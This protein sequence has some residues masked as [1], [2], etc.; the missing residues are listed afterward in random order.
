MIGR[1]RAE[2][3]PGGKSEIMYTEEVERRWLATACC[4]FTLLSLSCQDLT[5]TQDIGIV[6]EQAP[7]VLASGPHSDPQ[8]AVR[9]S[10]AIVLAVVTSEERGVADL[11]LYLSHSGGDVFEKRLRIN[12]EPG[13]VMSHSEGSPVFRMGP[14]SRFHAFW[15]TDIGRGVRALRTS[16]SKD[17]LNSFEAPITV[18]TGERGTPAFFNAEVSENGEVLAAWLG[19]RPEGDSVPGTA[20][21]LV[22]RSGDGG[23]EFSPP[24]AVAS[25]VCPCCRPA[26]VAGEDGDWIVAWRDADAENVRRIRVASSKDAGD[27]WEQWPQLPGPGWQINGCPHSGPAVALHQGVLHV[28]WYTEAEGIPALLTTSRSLDGG[29]FSELRSIAPEV[30]DANHPS[31]AVVGGRLFVAFQGRPP[32]E[33]DGWG[34][35]G[36]FLKELR[37]DGEGAIVSIPSGG[38]TASY[39]GITDLHAGRLLVGWTESSEGSSRVMGVRGRIGANR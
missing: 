24:V 30:K 28:V 2:A 19:Q 37:G 11:D 31:L 4:L 35:T 26:I 23:S 15:L 27:D 32:S 8:L 39:P 14:R 33:Q 1:T 22:S 34:K 13:S 12:R 5:S 9:A 16:F 6:F 18:T 21:L 3:G 20:H 38:G 36:I 17:F 7:R 25:N 29:V 10:G